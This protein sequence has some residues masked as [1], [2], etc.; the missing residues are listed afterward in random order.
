[1]HTDISSKFRWN[2]YDASVARKLIEIEGKPEQIR[3]FAEIHDKLTDYA[4]W[5]FLSTCWVSCT[6]YSDK[7]KAEYVREYEIVVTPIKSK[8]GEVIEKAE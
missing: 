8:D 7:D 5:F 3:Y 4:Y 2:P 1:M 6:G